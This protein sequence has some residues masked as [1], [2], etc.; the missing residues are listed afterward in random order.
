MTMPD[1]LT[2]LRLLT[3]LWFFVAVLIAIGSLTYQFYFEELLPEPPPAPA[4]QSS[5]DAPL[6][7]IAARV[8]VVMI[9]GGR[10]DLFNDVELM[11]QLERLAQKGRRG[12]SITQPVTVTLLSVLNIATGRT[13]GMAW[14]LQ[15][16]DADPYGDESVF[17]WAEAKGRRVAFVGDATWAQLFGQWSDFS[18]TDADKGI[19]S[20]HEGVLTVKDRRAIGLA[21][22]VLAD[23]SKYEVV[24]VHLTSVDKNAHVHG[25]L[26]RDK[27]QRTDYSNAAYALDEAIGAMHDRFNAPGD[28]WVIISDH[29]VTDSGTHGGGEMITKRAPFVVLGEG[30]ALGAPIEVMMTRWAA[31]LSLWLGLPIPRTAEQPAIFSLLPIDADARRR[32]MAHHAE[33]RAGF[34]TGVA[35]RLESTR[36][37]PALSKAVDVSEETSRAVLDESGAFIEALRGDRVW[38][39]W[40]GLGLGLVLHLLGLA[41]LLRGSWVSALNARA[42]WA[43]GVASAAAWMGVMTLMLMRDYWMAFIATQLGYRLWS[44]AAG[45]TTVI[46]GLATLTAVTLWVLARAARPTRPVFMAARASAGWVLLAMWIVG[47][48]QVTVKWP[49]GPLASVFILEVAWCV[50]VAG[51]WAARRGKNRALWGLSAVSAVALLASHFARKDR[52]LQMLDET[53]RSALIAALAFIVAGAAL[54]WTALRREEAP[55]ARRAVAWITIVIAGAAALYRLWPDPIGA[56][57][58]LPVFG[59]ALIALASASLQRDTK[60][61]LLFIFAL[62]VSHFIASDWAALL[63]LPLLGFA[64]VLSEI[65]LPSRPWVVM[66]LV[67]AMV[68]LDIATFYAIGYRYSF[69]TIDTR[70]PFLLDRSDIN[71]FVGGVLLILQ[72]SSNWIMLL[73]AAFSNRLRAQDHHGVWMIS[74][75]VIMVFVIR[76]WSPFFAMEFNRDDYWFV[77]HTSPMFVISLGSAIAVAFWLPIVYRVLDRA[78]IAEVTE[79]P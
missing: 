64:W 12:V 66:S 34:V 9:D 43:L 10:E 37:P 27:G 58:A 3:M 22:E 11:P 72:H 49:H 73:V 70:T 31:T 30:I 28:V 18:D 40:I 50:I 59:A 78:A 42:Q 39:R 54:C 24:V 74:V 57:I 68:L 33:R 79:R 16:F 65:R 51:V 71:L 61:D 20:K 14:S 5:L 76:C 69:T 41:V 19:Y 44:G 4:T 56:R 77:A 35:Q 26:L 29:G 46:L 25:G 45:A 13:P 15:N 23:P 32:V 67:G 47:L 7:A 60:R 1:R 17:Y 55:R 48:S 21:G 63:T 38:L 6:E 52:H 75:A 8:V 36:A 53:T 2:S 62:G